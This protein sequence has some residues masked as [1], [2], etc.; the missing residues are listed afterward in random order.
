MEP[1]F[2]SLAL[3]D[4]ARPDFVD[5]V[6]IP[7][8]PGADLDPARWAETVFA[9]GSAPGWVR[10]L[11]GIRQAL[12]RLIGVDRGEASVFAV[13]TVVGEE[14]LI[15]ADD[16]HLD[17][18]CGVGVDPT[19]GLVRVTTVVRLHGWRGR[20]YFAPVKVVHPLVVAA[21]LKRA[22]RVM[23]AAG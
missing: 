4:I 20:L 17:F 8:P 16:R 13:D 1:A 19:A 15:R 18:R 3:A 6:A 12:V 5:L 9:V 14:A 10:L 23:A 22:A 21:M 2:R 11:F 7:L